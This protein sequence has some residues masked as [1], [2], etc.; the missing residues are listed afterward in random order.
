MGSVSACAQLDAGSAGLVVCFASYRTQY[1]T[2]CSYEGVPITNFDELREAYLNG[3]T[4]PNPAYSVL[5][6]S[7]GIWLADEPVTG[8]SNR[9]LLPAAGLPLQQPVTPSKDSSP[10]AGSGSSRPTMCAN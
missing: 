6:G 2:D 3:F 5:T 1:F 4:G 9:V 8:P 10:S 7:A